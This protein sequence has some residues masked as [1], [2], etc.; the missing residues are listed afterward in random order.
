MDFNFFFF[1]VFMSVASFALA[2][3]IYVLVL[4]SFGDNRLVECIL[5]PACVVVFD[6]V[7][8]TMPEYR[9]FIGSLPLAGVAGMLGYAYFFKGYSY[10]GDN[11]VA[12]TPV[13]REEK[14]YSAKS[15][16][17]HETRK[18]RGRE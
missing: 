9:Y 3:I 18:R 11:S 2:F 12:P 10:G 16:R 5:I 13:S 1:L 7:C 14:K 6:F 8:L 4:K 15:K 17:I